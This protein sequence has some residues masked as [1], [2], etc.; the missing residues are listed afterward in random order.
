MVTLTQAT[1]KEGR[2]AGIELVQPP[3]D[4]K[5]GD[6]IYFEGPEYESKG[7]ILETAVTPHSPFYRR[8]SSLAAQS[9]EANI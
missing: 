1:A 7:C 8:R 4:S 2:E 5:P 6:R 9:K 3:P